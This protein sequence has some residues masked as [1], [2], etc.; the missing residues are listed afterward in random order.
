M[1][2]GRCVNKKE[3]DAGRCLLQLIALF[4]LWHPNVMWLAEIISVTFL[5]WVCEGLALGFQIVEL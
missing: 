1:I 5:S 3:Q 4:F 2:F